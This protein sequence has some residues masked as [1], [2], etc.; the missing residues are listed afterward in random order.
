MTSL[1]CM[2]E[3]F[4]TDLSFGGAGDV[5][6]HTSSL[7]ARRVISPGAWQEQ[8]G[9]D[10]GVATRGHVG[11]EDAQLAV[12]DFAESTAVLWRNT[13]RVFALLGKATLVDNE[14]TIGGR[15][16]RSE[17]ALQGAD[18]RSSGPGGFRQEALQRS[19]S[20]TGNSFGKVLGIPTVGMLEQQAAQVLFTPF[21]RFGTAKVGREVLMKGG[22]VVRHAF[23]RRSV[24]L[25]PPKTWR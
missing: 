24:H 14:D 17:I 8:A 6:G 1:S 3:Q 22:K 20:S 25:H 15:E 12:G 16:A 10:Q 7:A 13:D 4:K 5:L 2:A 18:D 9:I 19:R 11:Q 21:A 23:E